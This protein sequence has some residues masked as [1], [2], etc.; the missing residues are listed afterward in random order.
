MEINPDAYETE[1][2][3]TLYSKE[4]REILVKD[5]GLVRASVMHDLK[6]D[7]SALTLEKPL[8][9]SIP[10]IPELE[11]D[12]LQIKNANNEVQGLL[13]KKP[14]KIP[15]NLPSEEEPQILSIATIGIVR[16]KKDIYYLLFLSYPAK[17]DD[18]NYVS[19]ILVDANGQIVGGSP[20]HI[21]F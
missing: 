6:L 1:R 3:G 9:P 16:N 19:K 10:F 18:D 21:F 11:V 2:P 7:I 8:N 20:V 13:L 17:M 12:G 5:F 15:Y 4:I 14:F